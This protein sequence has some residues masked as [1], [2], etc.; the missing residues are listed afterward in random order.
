MTEQ[1]AGGPKIVPHEPPVGAVWVAGEKAHDAQAVTAVARGAGTAPA[2]VLAPATIN[3]PAA[4]ATPLEGSELG[5]ETE[6]AATESVAPGQPGY[7]AKGGGAMPYHSAYSA[8][9]E[10]SPRGSMMFSPF[11]GAASSGNALPRILI[12]PFCPTCRGGA[13]PTRQLPALAP[14]RAASQTVS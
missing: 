2:H 11:R 4:P 5:G 8:E 14:S 10:H 7:W 1:E 13:Q 3:M 12:C 9:E 6:T